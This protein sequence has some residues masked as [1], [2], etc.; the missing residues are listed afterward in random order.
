MHATLTS[1]GAIV[2]DGGPTLSRQQ[3]MVLIALAGQP[4]E[5]LVS[6]GV[7]HRAL[8]P[9][10]LDPLTPAQRAALSRTLARL[11]RW[12][13]ITRS[14]HTTA[15]I[16]PAGRWLVGWIEGWGCWAAY[17]AQWLVLDQGQ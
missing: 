16:S 2:F 11:E 15:Q 14:T 3:V 13:I 6:R 1:A 10:Q 8:W 4:P 7:L 5:Q 17:R 9:A 12:G